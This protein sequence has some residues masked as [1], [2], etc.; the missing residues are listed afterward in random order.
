MS[1]RLLAVLTK[2]AGKLDVP[3]A[4]Q[5][6]QQYGRADKWKEGA[7][8]YEKVAPLDVK[9]SAWHWKEAAQAW[10]KAKNNDKA[11]SAAKASAACKPEKRAEILTYSRARGLFLGVSLEGSTLRPNPS[12]NRRVYGRD[13]SAKDI[14]RGGKVA[15]PAAGQH[16][17][18]LLNTKSAK[19]LSDPTSL[20]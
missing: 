17:V 16:L 19:N 7:E 8:I 5:L 12:A 6:A 9:L 2:E 14:I 1:E 4:A 13:V 3:T 15:V 20:K 18:S 10:L 11:L